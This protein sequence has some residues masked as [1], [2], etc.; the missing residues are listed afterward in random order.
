MENPPEDPSQAVSGAAPA[1]P[2][3][4]VTYGQLEGKVGAKALE[5]DAQPAPLSHE[6]KRIETRRAPSWAYALQSLLGRQWRRVSCD[7]R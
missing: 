7:K 1:V 4:E 6:A 5:L 3:T 2:P